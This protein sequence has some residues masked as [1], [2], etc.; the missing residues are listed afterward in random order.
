VT[1][2]PIG[3]FINVV[4]P[5]SASVIVFNI[6]ENASAHAHPLAIT[7]AAYRMIL[8]GKSVNASALTAAH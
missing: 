8:S 1:P 3:S 4:Q 7:E 2:S 5:V 6:Y